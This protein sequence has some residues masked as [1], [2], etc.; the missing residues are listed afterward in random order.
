MQTSVCSQVGSKTADDAGAAGFGLVV[1]VQKVRNGIR[2]ACG[3]PVAPHAGSSAG[4]F[5]IVG[6]MDTEGG[7]AAPVSVRVCILQVYAGSLDQKGNGWY[8]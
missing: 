4:D 1:P 2:A 7:R 5:D 3:M 6:S 8:N